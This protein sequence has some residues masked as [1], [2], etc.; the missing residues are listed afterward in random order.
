MVD[1]DTDGIADSVD[2][3]PSADNCP[4]A[5]NTS[6]GDLDGDGRGDACEADVGIDIDAEILFPLEPGN[7]A[8]YIVNGTTTV[9]GSVPSFTVN[10]NGTPTR[11]VLV[12]GFMA[13]YYTND[14]HGF[15][16]HRRDFSNGEIAVLSPPIAVTA[17]RF[18]VGQTFS[19]S[20]ID[21]HTVPG[22]GVFNLNFNATSRI[23]AVE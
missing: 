11:K 20:G 1:Q 5:A 4:L 2:N 8:T 17:S 12:S 9:T 14:A 13:E 10:V 15:R 16:M 18:S 19:S 21:R 3:C 6:Q 7:H 23:E 22:Y